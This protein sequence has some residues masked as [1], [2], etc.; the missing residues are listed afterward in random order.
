MS[1][2]LMRFGDQLLVGDESLAKVNPGQ[3]SRWATFS[4]C[5]VDRSSE[6]GDVVPAANKVFRQVRS[7]IPLRRRD[8]THS[9]APATR[10]AG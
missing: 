4:T 5:P 10:T 1:D 8:Y 2:G 9:L 6:N 7:M 3:R